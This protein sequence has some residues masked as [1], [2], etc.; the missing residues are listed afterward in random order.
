MERIIDTHNDVNIKAQE[1]KK[2][3]DKEYGRAQE[4]FD[5]KIMEYI[6]VCE[7]GVVAL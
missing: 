6:V 5:R 1:I 7:A 2:C 4:L 3:Y